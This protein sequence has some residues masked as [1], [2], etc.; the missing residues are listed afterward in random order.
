M[1]KYEKPSMT[2]LTLIKNDIITTSGT[3]T[4]TILV[5]GEYKTA[6]SQGSMD[7]LSIG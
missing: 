2:V 4:N 1:K 5:N 3:P 6:T 7:F